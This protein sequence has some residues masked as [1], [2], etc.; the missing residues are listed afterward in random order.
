MTTTVVT[1]WKYSSSSRYLKIFYANGSGDLFYPVSP[2][3]YDNL[4]YRY[5]NLAQIAFHNATIPDYAWAN[6]VG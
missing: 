3:I 5:L 4:L 2:I 6:V 1:S